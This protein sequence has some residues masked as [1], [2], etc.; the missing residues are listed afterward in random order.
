M[1]DTTAEIKSLLE[2][3]W[4]R[5]PGAIQELVARAHARLCKL[6]AQ[7]MNVS[8]AQLVGKRE[9]DSVISETYL[10]LAKALEKVDLPTPADF[11]RFA[12]H[13]IRQTLLDMVAELKRIP[14]V[15]GQLAADSSASAP[16]VDRADST[17]NVETKAMW[18]ELHQQVE[19][20]PE[21]VKEV[22]ILCYY[23]DLTQAEVAAILEEHPREVSRLWFKG[24]IQLKKYIPED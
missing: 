21:N 13:K 19:T 10:R 22:F 16:V 4:D 7:I 11:F 6:A 8:F 18:A 1:D 20:L 15:T 5:E 3:V 17:L 14:V 12:A 9:V 24:T 23:M 2:R